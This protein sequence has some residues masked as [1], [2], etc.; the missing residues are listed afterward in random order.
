MI[1]RVASISPDELKESEKFA[2]LIVKMIHIDYR[3]DH[4]TLLQLLTNN[5]IELVSELNELL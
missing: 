5:F 2:N 1:D 4:S 3:D